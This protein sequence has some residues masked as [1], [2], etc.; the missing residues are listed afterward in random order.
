MY[1]FSFKIRFWRLISSLDSGH[2]VTRAETSLILPQLTVALTPLRAQIH[3]DRV[4]VGVVPF[5]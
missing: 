4:V 1:V 3:E 2:Q 5:G